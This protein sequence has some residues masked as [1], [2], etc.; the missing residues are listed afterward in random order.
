MIEKK[1]FNII[2]TERLILKPHEATFEYAV[3]VYNLI[4]ENWDFLTRFLDKMLNIKRPEDEYAFFV[5]CDKNWKD[6]TDPA[7]GIWTKDGQFIGACDFH[8]VDYDLH[9]AEI[10]YWLDKKQ[11][12]KGYITEAV[13]ALENEFFNRGFNRL[14]IVMDTE[15]TAS[16]KVA[17]RCGYTKEGLMREWHYN[18][19]FKSY[20]NMFLYSKL[21]SE[22]D[23]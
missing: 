10:G 11:A 4:K 16:E 7:Y 9:S 13:K 23:R 18:P 22:R 3:M 17:I 14:V 19:A 1:P 2:E 21:K 8:S 6:M 15:N 12:G 5:N 20:R